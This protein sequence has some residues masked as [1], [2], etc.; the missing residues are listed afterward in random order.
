MR[1][2]TL[3][4]LLVLSAALALFAGACNNQTPPRLYAT[5][6]WKMRCPDA[7]DFLPPANC[8][9][10][11]TEGMD[12]LIDNFAGEGGTSVTC[13]VTQNET[14]RI[15][16]FRLGNSAGQSVSFQN[17]AVPRN[18]GSAL[19]GTIRFR[20]DNDYTGVAGGSAPSNTQPCQV[21]NVEFFPE[22]ESGD[23]TIR[24]YVVCDLMRAD[25]DMRI[26]RGLSMPGGSATAMEPAE[27]T[28]YGCPGLVL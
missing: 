1:S 20:E 11:C 9:M 27:F 12:R 21:S 28:I 25:A 10:G 4:S 2:K 18:G 5:M 14:S 19:S 3:T 23:P 13:N 17:V 15:L 8:A 24:G 16:N 6:S 7:T 22:A 26:C